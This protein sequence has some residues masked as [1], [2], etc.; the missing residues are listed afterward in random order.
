MVRKPDRPRTTFCS[1]HR[2][3]ISLSTDRKPRIDFEKTCSA[4]QFSP[5]SMLICHPYS[6]LAGALNQGLEGG[7]LAKT[8]RGK[9][10]TC[11]QPFPK[12]Y[13][14]LRS[15]DFSELLLFCGFIAEESGIH[16]GRFSRKLLAILMNSCYNNK[17]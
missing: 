12:K 11:L 2:Q 16:I 17:G 10:G 9:L 6:F 3:G 5:A 7:A 14:E 1:R 8:A 4:D 15:S 13:H